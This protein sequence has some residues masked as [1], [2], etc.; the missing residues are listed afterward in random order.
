MTRIEV[1]GPTREEI[2]AGAIEEIRDAEN[3]REAAY[4]YAL[5]MRFI[6]PG[7]GEPWARI[8][9]A[10]CERWPKGLERV[11]TLAWKLLKERSK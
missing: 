8:N 3:Q 2:V 1:Y 6:A 7:F 5:A 4:T 9:A 10:V 11:K